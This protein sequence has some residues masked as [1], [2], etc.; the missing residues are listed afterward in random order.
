MV[1]KTMASAIRKWP[2]S[3]LAELLGLI[4]TELHIRTED[5]KRSKKN[6]AK[7][8]GEKP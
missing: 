6:R 3:D 2:S 4:H 7:H 5:A 1:P 8:K